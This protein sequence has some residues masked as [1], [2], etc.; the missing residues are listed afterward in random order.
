MEGYLSNI[1]DEGIK[2]MLHRERLS[3]EVACSVLEDYDTENIKEFSELSEHLQTT[4]QRFS[5][6][7]KLF[8]K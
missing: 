7:S 2:K 1:F 8:V 5:S 6:W 4:P 3:G